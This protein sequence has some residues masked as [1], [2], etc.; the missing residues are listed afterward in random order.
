MPPENAPEGRKKSVAS[1]VLGSLSSLVGLAT[2]IGTAVPGLK[3]QRDINTQRGAAGDVAGGVARAAVGASQTGFG[4]TRGLNLRTGLRQAG[5][6]AKESGGAIAQAAGR[7]ERQTELLRTARNNKLAEFGADAAD[8]AANIGFGIVEARKAKQEDEEVV[9]P[10]VTPG[11]SNEIGTSPLADTYA[12]EW[13]DQAGPQE[14]PVGPGPNLE[15]LGTGPLTEGDL[16][17]PDAP[18]VGLIDP[19]DEALGIPQRKVL[20][21]IA[22]ELELQ[23]RLEKFALDE[24]DKYGIDIPMLYSRIK[25]M[26]NLPYVQ[27]LTE[28]LEMD[29]GF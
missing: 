19:V 23:L 24:M 28:Q 1:G 11:V 10:G 9:T 25:R 21:Q 12:G 18:E 3:K 6:I 17:L 22:P 27:L 7:D 8:M 15:D 5:Q 13:M 29:E 14:L 4:A 2:Q 26:Q 20:Y 16:S